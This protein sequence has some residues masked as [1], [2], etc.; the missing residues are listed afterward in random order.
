MRRVLGLRPD[1]P[2]GEGPGRHR[3]A[4]QET[5]PLLRHRRPARTHRAHLGELGRRGSPGL[6][7]AAGRRWHRL[8]IAI[9]LIWDYAAPEHARS[10]SRGRTSAASLPPSTSSIGAGAAGHG[11]YFAPTAPGAGG[12]GPARD[13]VP[14]YGPTSTQLV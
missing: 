6:N 8:G 2:G 9:S 10:I 13:H 3:Q 12:P 11:A 14:H 5:H 1:E 7:H 4:A